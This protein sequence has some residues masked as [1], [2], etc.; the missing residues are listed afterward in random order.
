M[1]QPDDQGH[2]LHAGRIEKFLDDVEAGSTPA[3]AG[4]VVLAGRQWLANRKDPKHCGEQIKVQQD[5]RV[6]DVTALHLEAVRGVMQNMAKGDGGLKDGAVRD[7][8]MTVEGEFEV[9]TPDE[10][11]PGQ[12]QSRG[13]RA[14][15]RTRQA[16][17]AA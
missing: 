12:P 8:G 14:I 4:R 13:T 10:P 3:D 1:T 6:Q 11:A 9:V 16:H 5:V 2:W 17:S 7:E 15:E